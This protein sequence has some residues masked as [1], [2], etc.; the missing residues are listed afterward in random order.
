MGANGFAE[1][2]TLRCDFRA[3]C[4][5]GRT[6]PRQDARSRATRDEVG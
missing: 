3:S 2:A 6:H 5:R 1:I 4:G